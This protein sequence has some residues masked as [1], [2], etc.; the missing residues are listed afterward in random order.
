MSNSSRMA[1]SF[2]PAYF[3]H[4]R[5]N[6]RMSRSRSD[7]TCSL[8]ALSTVAA[9]GTAFA[10]SM[11]T[12]PG[13]RPAWNHTGVIL[14][15]SKHSHRLESRSKQRQAGSPAAEPACLRRCEV[16][17]RA[18]KDPALRLGLPTATHATITARARTPAAI[19]RSMPPA[20]ARPTA[21]GVPRRTRELPEP[22]GQAGSSP[23]RRGSPPRRRRSRKFEKI[24]ARQEGSLASFTRLRHSRY[25][26]MLLCSS[27]RGRKI[28]RAVPTGGGGV[29]LVVDLAGEVALEAAQDLLGGLA[30][31]EPALH[32]GLG[33]LVVAQ[34]GDHGP[35]QGGIG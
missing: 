14:R 3:H 24:V 32:V 25:G 12:P 10:A 30:F 18:G 7:R 31:G 8:I 11:P 16:M 23:P 28:V 2:A 5:S 13:A 34:S 4:C 19:R 6:A 27:S 26:V 9:Q 17:R 1:C 20:T 15:Q 21:N 33:R 22:S 35:M 29:E